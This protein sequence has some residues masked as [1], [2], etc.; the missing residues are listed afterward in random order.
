[1]SRKIIVLLA[2][3]FGMVI[4]IAIASASSAD[5]VQHFSSSSE[6]V[7]GK[8]RVDYM[9]YTLTGYKVKTVHVYL[10]SS[11]KYLKLTA[12]TS[13]YRVTKRVTKIA[14]PGGPVTIPKGTKY[15]VRGNLPRNYSPKAPT[16][17]IAFKVAANIPLSR[18]QCVRVSMT[19]WAPAQ[20]GLP[21]Y[22]AFTPAGRGYCVPGKRW[23]T[24]I[25]RE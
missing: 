11:S 3:L 18:L 20:D 1:M 6:L 12:G 17:K 13:P 5:D 21:A 8:N 10:L 24:P 23:L 7:P 4:P 25:I 14:Q 9:V 19:G 15:W 22:N 2:A 16:V